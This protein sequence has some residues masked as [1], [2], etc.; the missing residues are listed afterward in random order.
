[1]HL[2]TN[3]IIEYNELPLGAY[4]ILNEFIKNGSL[5]L[6]LASRK[7]TYYV[8]ASTKMQKFNEYHRPRECIYLEH[9]ETNNSFLL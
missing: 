3:A 5:V 6:T 4:V 7:K 8:Y 1:M 2:R 9:D